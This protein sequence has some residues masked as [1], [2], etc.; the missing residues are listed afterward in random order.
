M[1]VVFKDN[2]LTSLMLNTNPTP[3]AQKLKYWLFSVF[4][5]YS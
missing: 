5:S 1:E 2:L 4:K 3:N